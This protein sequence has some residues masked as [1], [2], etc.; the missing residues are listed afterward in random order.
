MQPRPRR[1]IPFI[2]CVVALFAVLSVLIGGLDQLE[3]LPGEALP[4]PFADLPEETDEGTYTADRGTGKK[5]LQTTIR[6]LIIIALA[7]MVVFSVI[8][9]RFRW[10]LIVTAI[11]F[12]LFLGLTSFITPVE[13]EPP[14]MGPMDSAMFLGEPQ[15]SQPLPTPDIPEASAPTW[16]VILLALGV[17]LAITAIIIAVALK[18]LPRI[19]ARADHNRGLLEE[20]AEQ[21][22][23]ALKQIQAGNDPYEVV[24]NSYKEMIR[25]LSPKEGVRNLAYLT[26]REFSGLLRSRGMKD[27]H[28][29]RLTSIFELV[30][31]GDRSQQSFANEALTCLTAIHNH[32]A[33]ADTK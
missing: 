22:N 23:N 20:L 21:A 4:N 27:I 1:Y 25:I 31:Y 14:Q 3:L 13:G 19:R 18:I 11:I 7:V 8:S 5:A 24:L 9:P 17:G 16:L 26:A 6:V 28:I 33:L 12:A 29:D 15:D 2:V 30:R 10:Q 32:Y